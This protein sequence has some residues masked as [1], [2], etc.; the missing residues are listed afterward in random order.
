MQRSTSLYIVTGTTGSIGSVIAHTLA[1]EGKAVVL[2]CRNRNKAEKQRE[3][4]ISE[5]GNEDIHCVELDLD[6]MEAVKVACESIKGLNRPIAAIVNNA[7][8][9]SRR[10]AIVADSYEQDFLVNTFSTALFTIQLIPVMEDNGTVVFT[11][12]LTRDVWRLPKIFPKEKNFGQLATYGRSKRAVTMFSVWLNEQLK[13]RGIKVNCADPGVVD[14]GMIA[15]D[16]WFDPIA[17]VLFRPLISTPE[18]G[19][20][21]ALNALKSPLSGK[22]FYHEKILNPSKSILKESERIATEILKVIGY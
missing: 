21:S 7:G 2:A 17:D 22:I 11:T 8:V 9:M 4:L 18:K 13:S 5:T 15:M 3:T 6:N 10:S 12:S 1:T 14:T 19:A 20:S 16:R